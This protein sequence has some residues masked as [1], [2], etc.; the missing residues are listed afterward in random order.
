MEELNFD[1]VIL[2]A[3]SGGMGVAYALKKLFDNN[4]LFQDETKP[5]KIAIV[6]KNPELGGTATLGWVTSWLQGLIPPHME[7]IIEDLIGL[8]AERQR[9]DYWL[10]DNFAKDK[11]SENPQNPSLYIDGVKLAK[12]YKDDV[13]A[14]VDL[15]LNNVIVDA[16]SSDGVVK[17]VVTQDVNT[18]EQKRLNSKFFVD[19]TGDGVLCRLVGNDY[20]CGRDPFSRFHEESAQKDEAKETTCVINEASLLYRIE[21]NYDDSEL[22]SH[23]E[24]VTAQYNDSNKI[25]SVSSPDYISADGFASP[26][27]ENEM[28]KVINPMT[29][30]SNNPYEILINDHMQ[31]AYGIYSKYL[32]EHWKFIKLSCRQSMEMGT[33]NFHA[34]SASLH[35]FGYVDHAPLLGIRESYRIVC[36]EMMTQED[37]THLITPQEVVKKRFVGESSHIVDIHL[38]DG[39]QDVAKFN[40]EKLRPYGIKYEALIPKN[41][42]NVLIASRCYGASQIFLSGARGNFTMAYLGYSV[43]TAI[44]LCIHDNLKDV[45]CVDVAK[46]QELSEFKERVDSLQELYK[47]GL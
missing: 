38:S 34:Y 16:S 5:C 30:E 9:D 35:E 6:D 19:S 22:L 27:P 43:G 15:I 32:L 42:K 44:G 10:R 39:L 1:A 37:M 46:V 20:L 24:T 36:D 21:K 29:G 31:D 47:E 14:F 18:G 17:Y 33:G 25:L 41:L 23:V 4:G 40:K 12:R 2:G 26:S 8:T 13:E 7:V 11:D 28:M 45:R 3:G